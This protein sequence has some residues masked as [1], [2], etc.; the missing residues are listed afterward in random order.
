VRFNETAG[1][2]AKDS[3][4][5]AASVFRA[6]T[7]EELSNYDVHVNVV[8]GGNIDGP[9]AGVAILAA[10]ISAV[11]G[12]PIPQDIAV[13]GEISLRGKVKAIGGLHA[14]IYG[15][16]QGGVRKVFVPAENMDNLPPAVEG[17]EVVPIEH[18]QDFLQQI[19]PQ[20]LR[21]EPAALVAR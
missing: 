8:G 6:L 3:V 7:G 17:V 10:I 4:F 12:L 15:A 11:K 19:F 13:T 9:S 5:N 14:K 2:M 18:V 1:S 16:K 21:T 20:G